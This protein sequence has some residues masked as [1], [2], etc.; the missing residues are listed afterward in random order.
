MKN[1]NMI[2]EM[3]KYSDDFDDFDSLE[4]LSPVRP[5]KSA[6]KREV[7]ALQEL[8]NALV[9]LTKKQLHALNLPHS[10]LEA[11]EAAQHMPQHEAKRRQLQYIGKV[12]REIDEESQARIKNYFKVQ[13]K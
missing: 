11:V 7:T 1:K 3:P 5:S 6:R 8:G 4:E 9:K 2:G 13:G 12:M 10:L